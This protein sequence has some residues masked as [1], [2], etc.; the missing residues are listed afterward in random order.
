MILDAGCGNRAMWKQKNPEDVVFIDIQKNLEKKPTIFAD[1]QKMPLKTSSADTIFFDPPFSWATDTHPFFSYP[2]SKLQAK[3]YPK[4]I[5]K[6]KCPTYYGVEIYRSRYSLIA[7][8]YRAEK[9]LYRVLKNDG[10]LWLRWCNMKDDLT[11]KRILTI[12][13]NWIILLVHEI[14]SSKQVLSMRQD[15]TPNKSYWFM[16]MKKRLSF[17]QKSLV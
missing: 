11:H 10:C 13:E 1:T 6:G 17:K 8:I 3:K 7:Y 5:R 14:V 16:L 9:E 4:Y 15:K 2:N 12:F